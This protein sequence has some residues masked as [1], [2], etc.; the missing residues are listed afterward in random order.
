LSVSRIAKAI[1]VVQWCGDSLEIVRQWPAGVRATIGEELRRLQK[2]EKP[3]DWKPFLGSNASAFELRD[4]VNLANSR[5]KELLAIEQ[6]A[7]HRK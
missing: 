5:L 1:K 4:H 6:K 2:G 3:R 7:E